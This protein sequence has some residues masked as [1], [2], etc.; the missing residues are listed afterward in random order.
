MLKLIK[1]TVQHILNISPIIH[2]SDDDQ[3][4]DLGDAKRYSLAE[5][6]VGPR[7]F[8]F[9]SLM[10]TKDGLEFKIIEKLNFTDKC[11]IHDD[12]YLESK[13]QDYEFIASKESENTLENQMDFLKH[14][15]SMSE[16][17][18]ASGY[19][20]INIYSAIIIAHIGFLAYLLSQIVDRQDNNILLSV[21][22]FL[23]ALTI[24]FIINSAM[25]ITHSLSIKGYFRSAFKDL[26]KDSSKKNLAKA[27]YFD[28]LSTNNESHVI[29]S[30]VLNTEKY[31]IRGFMTSIIVW[32]LILLPENII[33]KN[34]IIAGD[35]GEY[36]IFDQSGNFQ[37]LE[38]I[39]LLSNIT[40]SSEK[41]YV[42]KMEKDENG[43]MLSKFIKIALNNSERV[44]DLDIKNQVMNPHPVIVKQED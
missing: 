24:Y 28:F 30:I 44:I 3:F 20:K 27:Y 40:E 34:S 42:I 43:I 29:T 41:I 13:A 23:Y 16:S 25:F 5:L 7:K 38:F 1:K 2:V 21:I 39:R 9:F 12:L 15:I 17:R 31:F 8:Y 10:K 11:K 18:T 22:V 35:K 36:Y 37:R 6:S 26:K 4:G 19:N 14:K 33:E 32:V